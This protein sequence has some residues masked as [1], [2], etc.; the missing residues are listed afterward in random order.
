MKEGDPRALPGKDIPKDFSEGCGQPTKQLEGQRSENIHKKDAHHRRSL[1][2]PATPAKQEQTQSGYDAR[3]RKDEILI[4]SR[5]SRI[6][7][8]DLEQFAH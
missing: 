4:S 3:L 7:V 8:A 2:P 1:Q 6:P 5:P